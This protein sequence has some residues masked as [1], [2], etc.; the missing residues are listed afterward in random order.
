MEA[1]AASLCVVD[2][3]TRLADTPWLRASALGT[4]AP[5]PTASMRASESFAGG[6]LAMRAIKL[7]AASMG[8]T[9]MDTSKCSSF[10]GCDGGTRVADGG[11]G[12]ADSGGGCGRRD[13]GDTPVPDATG[14]VTPM[15]PLPPLPPADPTTSTG[16]TPSTAAASATGVAAWRERDRGV[17]DP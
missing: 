11:G 5:A 13:D 10:D 15:P 1:D 17:N 14:D 4:C 12:S 7:R 6:S 16:E 9:A 3:A 2:G 8:R